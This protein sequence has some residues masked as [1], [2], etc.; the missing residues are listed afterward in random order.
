M[1]VRV[2]AR[3]PLIT[4]ARGVFDARKGGLPV[5]GE[6]GEGDVKC[7]GI[8]VICRGRLRDRSYQSRAPIILNVW[9]L[10]TSIPAVS[11]ESFCRIDGGRVEMKRRMF[12]RWNEGKHD[13][14]RVTHDD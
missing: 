4:Q 8:V 9:E 6:I 11:S 2:L 5:G 7:A 14:W 10:Q 3:E 1:R 13:M 12:V